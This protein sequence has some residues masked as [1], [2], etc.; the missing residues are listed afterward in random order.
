ML[1]L[2]RWPVQAFQSAS[3]TTRLSPLPVRPNPQRLKPLVFPDAA[4]SLKRCPDTNPL[5]SADTALLRHPGT[6]LLK[7]LTTPPSAYLT[8]TAKSTK[9]C[10]LMSRWKIRPS[11]RWILGS[12]FVLML[13]IVILPDVDLPDTAFHRGTAPVVVHS[14]ATAAPTSVPVAL[15]FHVPRGL[16]NTCWANRPCESHADPGPNFRPILFRSIRC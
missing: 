9:L 13:I 1:R 6:T 5:R 2:A 4:A 11:A 8:S 12:I 3:K 14:Q 15:S 10:G 16:G 7:L